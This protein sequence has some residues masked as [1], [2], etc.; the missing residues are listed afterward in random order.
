MTAS[1]DRTGF[2]A[3]QTRD[4][5]LTP[6]RETLLDTVLPLVPFEGW[7]AA[8]LARAAGEAGVERTLVKR[9]LPGGVVDLIDLYALRCDDTMAA[10]MVRLELDTMKVRRKITEAVRVR[11]DAMTAH[12]DAAYKALQAM[13]HPGRGVLG[14]RLTAR[15]ADRI[16]RAA[17]D[18]ST[19]VNYY[20]KR[21]TLSAVLGST[22]LFYFEDETVGHEATWAFLD[23]RIENVMTFEKVK[24]QAKSA[25]AGLPSP[26]DL[27]TALRY[28]DPRR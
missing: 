11:I 19:D 12:K 5:S 13:G 25:F 18:T 9:A 22:A 23:R 7:T 24:A 27:L 1:S 26:L 6:I 10:H 20:T 2:G 16:W 4:D 15:T 3:R 8:V 14:L 21:A 28:P 17:G